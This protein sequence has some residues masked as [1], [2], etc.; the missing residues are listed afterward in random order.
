MAQ[1][2]KCIRGV[3]QVNITKEIGLIY[4]AFTGVCVAISH[5]FVSHPHNTI[6]SVNVKS[7]RV[8]ISTNLCNTRWE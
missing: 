2:V 8:L 4:C 1:S 6:P 7:K 3:V 5:L